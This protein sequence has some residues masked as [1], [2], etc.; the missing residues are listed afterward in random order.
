MLARKPEVG[1]RV[2]VYMDPF[3]QKTLEG[4]VTLVSKAK[5]SFGPYETWWVKFSGERAREYNWCDLRI[6]GPI[7]NS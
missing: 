2:L 5:E 3:E 7:S 4:E 6:I 1:D